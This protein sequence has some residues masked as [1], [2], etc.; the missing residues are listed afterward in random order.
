MKDR[1]VK[2]REDRPLVPLQV[3]IRD[4]VR[5]K[6]KTIAAKNGLSLNDV[7]S[8][9]LAAGHNIVDAKLSEIHEPEA[10]AKA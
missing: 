5:V 6:L 1:S 10:M 9:C 3:K 8:M 4:E 7:A 2:S